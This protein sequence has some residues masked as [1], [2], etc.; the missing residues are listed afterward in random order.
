MHGYEE[1]GIEGLLRRMN[2]MFAF[3]IYDS[4]KREFVIARDR[5]GQKPLYYHQA[6]GR[7]LFG[8]EV[9]SILQSQSRLGRAESSRLLTHS[10]PCAT[11]RSRRRCSR[12][13]T[14]LPVAHYLHYKLD[15][16]ALSISRYWEVPLLDVRTAT[17][18]SEAE[19]FEALESLF[20]D[21]S[22]LHEE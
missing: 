11:C 18:K 15:S 20:T 3:C 6:N 12:A 10:S 2:G 1:W 22:A 13:S 16:G 9:K 17:Y 8:S 4:R 21:A 5:C 14:S 19:Y 7:F